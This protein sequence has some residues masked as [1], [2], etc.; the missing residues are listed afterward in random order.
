[1]C[2]HVHASLTRVRHTDYAAL[3]EACVAMGE[4]AQKM[5]ERKRDKDALADL[6]AIA[7]RVRVDELKDR[8]D[9]MVIA[10]GR[11]IKEKYAVVE[12]SASAC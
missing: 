4:F 10:E 7:E 6:A 2:C 11:L 8:G 12:V 3:D 1:M 5:N 9:F